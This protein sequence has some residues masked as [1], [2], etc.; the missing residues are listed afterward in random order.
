MNWEVKHYGVIEV[1]M[2]L[3]DEAEAL[4]GQGAKDVR[5][6][7]KQDDKH[8]PERAR[9]TR[10][11]TQKAHYYTSVSSGCIGGKSH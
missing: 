8:H 1:I 5:L 7:V 3:L 10:V 6:G 2:E 4:L 11:G 9:V